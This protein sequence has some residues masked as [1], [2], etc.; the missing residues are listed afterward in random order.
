[1]AR[2][3]DTAVPYPDVQV[4]SVLYIVGDIRYDLVVGSCLD[5]YWVVENVGPKI[6]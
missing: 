2:I 3:V 1:M 5:D 4:C 6:T